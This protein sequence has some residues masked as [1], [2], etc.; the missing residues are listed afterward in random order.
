IGSASDSCT[1]SV[2]MFL[3]LNYVLQLF[4]AL[5][6]TALV[7]ACLRTG[8][9]ATNAPPPLATS[10]NSQRF[11]LV[12]LSNAYTHSFTSL[13]TNGPWAAIP[14]GFQTNNG[15][16]FQIGGKLEVTGMDDA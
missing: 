9:A 7:T 4:R 3:K 5:L 6:I 12:D 2:R 13:T 15:V 8:S 16:P 11:H 10:T 14:R 1:E